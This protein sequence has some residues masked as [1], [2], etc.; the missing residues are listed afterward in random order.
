MPDVRK[1]VARNENN[2][3]TQPAKGEILARLFRFVVAAM[4]TV[5][6]A[7]LVTLLSYLLGLWA[8]GH[9][10]LEQCL[11]LGVLLP[12]F[13]GLLAALW[14]SRKLNWSALAASTAG[15]AVGL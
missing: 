8:G 12:L 4:L 13:V 15:A 5:A 3:E 1:R 6:V 9:V 14:P 2:E 7:L 10:R 11:R